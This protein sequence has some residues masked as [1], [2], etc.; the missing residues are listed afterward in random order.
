MGG[1]VRLWEAVW[2]AVWEAMWEAVGGC[3][4]GRGRPWEAVGGHV[5][6]RIWPPTASQIELSHLAKLIDRQ[7]DQMCH[8]SLISCLN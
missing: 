5:G 4:G 6:G 3:F 2:E 7:I 1:H 8:K